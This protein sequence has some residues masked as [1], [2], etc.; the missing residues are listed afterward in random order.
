MRFA[1]TERGFGMVAHQSYP[2]EEETRLL[3]HSSAIHPDYEDGLSRPG[4]SYLWIGDKHHLNRE[5]VTLLVGRLQSW[6]DTGSLKLPS[7][8]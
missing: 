4:S 8:E 1:R 5:E 6:L 3:Q 7:E 2:T